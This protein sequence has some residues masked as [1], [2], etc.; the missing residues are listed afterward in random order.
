VLCEFRKRWWELTWSCSW[1]MSESLSPAGWSLALSG[2]KTWNSDL[3]GPVWPKSPGFGPA[4]GGF[5]SLQQKWREMTRNWNKRKVLDCS[6]CPRLATSRFDHDPTMFV[7]ITKLYIIRH[8]SSKDWSRV[9]ACPFLLLARLSPPQI[10]F[11]G[12]AWN[13]RDWKHY[14]SRLRTWIPWHLVLML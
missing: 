8:Q 12:R 3:P 1:Y 10:F 11:I 6:A 14:Q 4:W 2:C 13:S 5:G 7:T 9:Y